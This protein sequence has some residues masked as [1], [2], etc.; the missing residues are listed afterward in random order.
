MN[1]WLIKIGEPLPIK[2]NTKKMRAALLAEQLIERGHSVVR[3]TSAFDHFSKKWLSDKD[4]QLKINDN[5]RII[6]LR[7]IGYKKNFSLRRFIDHRIIA[8]KFRRL[9]R[10]IPQPDIIVVSTPPYDL[11]YE[12]VMYAKRAHIPVLV[13][14]RDEWPDLFLQHIPV[15]LRSLAK[16]FLAQDF[17]MAKRAMENADALIAIAHSLLGWGL[18]Y[19][20]RAK[21]QNDRVFYL[22]SKKNLIDDS[23]KNINPPYLENLKNK[24]IIVFIGSFVKN[25][26][27]FVI[28]ECAKRLKGEN[29]HFVLAGDGELLRAAKEKAAGLPNV[30]FTGWLNEKEVNILLRSSYIGI[31][32]AS[33]YRDTFPNKIFSYF[34]AGLPVISAFQGDAKDFIEK[35]Q[36]GFYY[37]PNDINS[38]T[39]CVKRL[40]KDKEFYRNISNNVRKIFEERFDADKIY[41][42]YAEHIE[43]IVEEQSKLTFLR[44]L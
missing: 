34:S 41:A 3:W 43:K 27:P 16:I 7:G 38:L 31:S 2:N 42:E 44:N 9:A 29:I 25:N 5:F 23:Y 39:K 26:D 18:K 30:S 32:P 22:G 14:I 11:A 17:L 37:P 15:K 8:R 28:I 12:A 20:G 4:S 6:F 13:D 35:Y 33:Q 10:N 24:F 40:C 1:I 36:L 21:T 19:A